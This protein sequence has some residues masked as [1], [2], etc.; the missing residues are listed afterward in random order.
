MDYVHIYVDKTIGQIPIIGWAPY[1]VFTDLLFNS[2]QTSELDMYEVTLITRA[3]HQFIY[4]KNSYDEWVYYGSANCINVNVEEIA[5]R[6]VG[7]VL[8]T[9]P[10]NNFYT[11]A[12]DNYYDWARICHN[13]YPTGMGVHTLYS[14]IYGVG[15]TSTNGTII[16]H[17]V[18]CCYYPHQALN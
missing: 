15:V 12:A 4:A 17:H 14:F 16:S 11:V 18:N 10:R 2:T 9:S 7:A 3:V 6:Y 5:R 1:E 8:K 13:T